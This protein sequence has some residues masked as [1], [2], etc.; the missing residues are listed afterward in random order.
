MLVLVIWEG[1]TV[2]LL[3]IV[4]YTYWL[5]NPLSVIVMVIV[6]QST[7]GQSIIAIVIVRGKTSP[8]SVTLHWKC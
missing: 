6:G 4:S 1:K 3:T 2:D 8:A 5:G 7:V